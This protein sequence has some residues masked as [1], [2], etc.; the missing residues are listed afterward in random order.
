M[1]REKSSSKVAARWVIRLVAAGLL[2]APAALYA[3]PVILGGDDLTQHGS[4]DGGGNNQ[5]G[6]LY[7]E[8]AVDNVLNPSTNI[9]RPGN[10]G[11]IAALGSAASAATSNDAGAAIGSAA[12]AL[13]K[14]VNYF[15][16]AAAINQF[17]TDLGSGAVNPAML[18]LAGSGAPNDLESDEGTALTD[19][20]AAIADF[21]NSGGGLMAHGSGSTAY[22]WLT[23]LLP[24]L[25]EVSGCEEVGA[26]L[27]A[28]G[29]AAFPG[30]SDSDI[31]DN[32]GPC[33]SHFEGNLGSLQVLALDGS[34]PPVPYIIGGGAGTTISQT[35]LY[36]VP[37][38]STWGLMAL[39]TLLA[40]LGAMA[41]RG[42][43]S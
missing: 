40:A 42:G 4:V 25:M 10:D 29:Q 31:D 7:I 38:L 11:T 1:S 21:V 24:D 14:T 15:D 17:F 33:H 43:N 16:G 26:M 9:T 37:T 32:A 13:G 6:W 18:W 12:A 20:A 34:S 19:N 41:L 23:A 3:G 28:A 2:L 35:L 39:V 8:K 30:L 27:T 5:D 36:E 22:G